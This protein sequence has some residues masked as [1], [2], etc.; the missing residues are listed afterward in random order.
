MNIRAIKKADDG[1]IDPDDYQIVSEWWEARNA[2]VPPRNLLPTLGIILEIDTA[3]AACGFLYL[4]ATGS[5]IAQLG[6][7]ATAPDLSPRR[8]LRY[9][10]EV[11]TFLE[12][13]AK[14]QGY[15]LIQATFAAGA[16]SRYMERRRY[17]EGDTNLS[18]L[19]KVL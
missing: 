4:D 12:N 19:F 1:R 10:E 17:R 18:H 11:I 8:A 15:W 5:G 6:W 13:E 2:A 3:P 16:L 14:A 9:L 7:T